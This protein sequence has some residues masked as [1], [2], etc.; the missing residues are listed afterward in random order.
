MFDQYHYLYIGDDPLSREVMQVAIKEVL[1]A[2]CLA[3][4]ASSD[5]FIQRLRDLKPTPDLIMLGC[6]DISTHPNKSA[7]KVEKT[8]I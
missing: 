8:R 5:N 7:D 2:P 4:F 1:G 6:V 3:Q